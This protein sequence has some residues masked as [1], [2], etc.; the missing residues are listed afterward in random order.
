MIFGSLNPLVLPAIMLI[1]TK[2]SDPQELP[3]GTINT[4]FE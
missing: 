2:A 3:G 4:R 1:C